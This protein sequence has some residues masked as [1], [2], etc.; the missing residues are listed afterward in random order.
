M[1]DEIQLKF[2]GLST[3]ED[4]IDMW[5]QL[6]Q[7]KDLADMNVIWDYTHPSQLEPGFNIVNI[8]YNPKKP[9]EIG[10]YCL[11]TLDVDK[12]E[13]DY[14]NPVGKR[15]IDDINKLLELQKYYENFDV[16]IDLSGKQTETSD[17]CGYHCLTHAYNLYIPKIKNVKNKQVKGKPSHTY[18]IELPE[19][20][21]EIGDTVE[22]KID[23]IIKILR[24]IY[25]GNKYGYENM[26]PKRDKKKGKGFHTDAGGL[27]DIPR[28]QKQYNYKDLKRDVEKYGPF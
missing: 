10:H 4:L 26:L 23:Q 17:N 7:D 9:D 3:P 14:Y 27:A 21:G 25:Y 8:L 24:G 28:F 15:T 11:I 1:E 16:R 20:G 5:K 22:D 2:S 6:K 13:I 12:E 19:K 18:S